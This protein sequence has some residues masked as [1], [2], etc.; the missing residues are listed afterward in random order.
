MYQNLL[1]FDYNENVK[2]CLVYRQRSLLGYP[3][4]N[5]EIAQNSMLFL[6]EHFQYFFSL[7]YLTNTLLNT[8]I[9]HL[10]TVIKCTYIFFTLKQ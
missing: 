2:H 10:Q 9:I 6:A 7:F 8:F 5:F 1:H 3:C 4:L